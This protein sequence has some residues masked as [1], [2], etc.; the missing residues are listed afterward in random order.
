MKK[1]LS[2]QRNISY[3]KHLWNYSLYEIYEIIRNGSYN[4]ND[5][6]AHTALIQ[7]ESDHDKQNILK[8]QLLPYVCI[9]GRFTE[10]TEA[11]LMDYSC[12]TAIDFDK[13]QTEEELQ[14]IGYWLTQTP[15]VK[16]IF[17]SP[18][19][20][21][22]K[23]IIEHSN[24]NPKKHRS[25]YRELMAKFKIPE[26]DTKTSDLSRATFLCY[27]PNAW[28]NDK[29]VPYMFDESKYQDDVI[30]T[31]G[32]GGSNTYLCGSYEEKI[33]TLNSLTCDGKGITDGSIKRIIGS[34]LDKECIVEGD[35]NNCLFKYGCKLCNAGVKYDYAL[36]LLKD[37][38]VRLGLNVEEVCNTVCNAY[39]RCSDKYGCERDRYGKRK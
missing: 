23:A 6:K 34:W 30:T 19:G 38:F 32:N 2:T 36:Q 8:A 7:S 15:C 22:L 26:T 12:Y 24:T 9:N 21:G 13:F 5:L 37:V 16:M 31:V 10:R 29:C 28:W 25:L 11:G 35:R 14:N 1:L 18:S 17:R 20:R 39:V 4:Y 27:D 3:T 33:K